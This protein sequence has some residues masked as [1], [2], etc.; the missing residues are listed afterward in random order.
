MIHPVRKPAPNRRH[1][2]EKGDGKPQ[3]EKEERAPEAA[4]QE[5][6]RQEGGE[7][8]KDVGPMDD[9]REQG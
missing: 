2:R 4:I 7:K 1:L 5:A 3:D 8:D 6:D 9:G